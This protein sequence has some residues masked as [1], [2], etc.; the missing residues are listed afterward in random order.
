M[1]EYPGRRIS[2]Y[3][4]RA[5]ISADPASEEPGERAGA[6]QMDLI[7]APQLMSA[8][9]GWPVRNGGSECLHEPRRW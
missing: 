2:M 7:C 9:V 1:S 8:K 5:L 6:C 4:G 3:E